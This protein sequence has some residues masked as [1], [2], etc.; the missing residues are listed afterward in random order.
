MRKGL[1]LIELIFTIVIIAIVFTVI[2][3]IV[4]ALNKADSFIIRQDA[5]FN[6]FSMI[7]MISNLPWD[8]N[9]TNS[10][11]ILHVT[12][13]DCNSST[14]FYRVGGFVGSRTCE[15]N[16]SASSIAL[17]GDYDDIDDFNNYDENTT[18]KGN[19]R[20]GLHVEVK[21]INDEIAYTSSNAK[22]DLNKSEVSPTTNLK[23]VDINVTYK[24]SR[25][26][27]GKQLTQ[28]NYTSAN[29]G[30]MIL[31]KRVWK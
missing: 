4:F 16:F 11:D 14:D 7:K 21:Y 19:L 12:K 9:N 15:D 27:Q 25:G 24:G 28:F 8:E 10:A 22:L 18:S 1:T 29:I 30:Q 26:N 20:Y 3:K 17:E 2:P 6:G 13:S 31:H 5:M 23:Y